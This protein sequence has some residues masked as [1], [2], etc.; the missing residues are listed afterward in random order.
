MFAPSK[1]A[2]SGGIATLEKI[3][4]VL[5]TNSYVGSFN[6]DQYWWTGK[7]KQKPLRIKK[8]NRKPRKQTCKIALDSLTKEMMDGT[9]CRELNFIGQMQLQEVNIISSNLRIPKIFTTN[10]Q[11]EWH[12]RHVF[13]LD[14]QGLWSKEQFMHGSGLATEVPFLVAGNEKNAWDSFE[15][16]GLLKGGGVTN[17]RPIREW[18]IDC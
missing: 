10:L 18:L 16:C 1:N 4:Y 14:S 11:V 8:G 13:L 3:R 2:I 7:K 15:N 5:I 17:P 6:T 12:C 9:N